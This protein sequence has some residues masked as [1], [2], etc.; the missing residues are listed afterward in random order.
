MGTAVPSRRLRGGISELVIILALIAVVI[1]VV[2]IVQSWLSRN[3]SGLDRVSAMPS[4]V[5]YII[6]RARS[7]DTEILTVGIRNQDQAAF[8]VTGFRAIVSDGSVRSATERSGNL[9][10]VLS[11]GEEKVFVISVNNLSSSIRVRGIVVISR[12]SSSGRIVETLINVE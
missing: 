6:S 8:E 10:T 12:E 1:P 2:M 3:A 5:G 11:P 9:G 7:G 4:L